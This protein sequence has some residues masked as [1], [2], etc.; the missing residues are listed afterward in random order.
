M[1]TAA[2]AAIAYVSMAYVSMT[3]VSA[4]VAARPAVIA[5]PAA[6]IEALANLQSGRWELRSRTEASMNRAFCMTDPGILLQLRHS[7]ARCSRF[8]VSSDAR[9][10]TVTYSCPLGGNGRTVIK[11]ETPRL[12][13]I[14]TQG[15]AD[16]APF[17][18]SVE[19]RRVGDCT[20]NGGV[21]HR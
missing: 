19:A 12:V 10:A 21:A 11:V 6:A 8:V 5:Q 20:E 4:V 3:G 18:F 9:N 15:I 7:T 1:A 16:N 2:C 13:Q 17:A 14:E